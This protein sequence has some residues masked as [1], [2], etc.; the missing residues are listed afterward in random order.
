MKLV[1]TALEGLNK[2]KG[3][4]VKDMLKYLIAHYYIEVKPLLKFPCF[5]FYLHSS[6]LLYGGMKLIYILVYIE[7]WVNF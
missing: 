3:A 2:P 4:T 5:N 6:S 1:R 7:Q